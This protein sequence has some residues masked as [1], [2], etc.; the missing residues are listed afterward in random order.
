MTTKASKKIKLGIISSTMHSFNAE[1][2][3]SDIIEYLDYDK[4]ELY[5]YYT[6][7]RI[8][9]LSNKFKE[10]SHK[11]VQLE[12][13]DFYHNAKTIAEDGIHILFDT[14][15]YLKGQNLNVLSFK[16]A[17]IQFMGYG[18]WGVLV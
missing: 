16:P 2:F 9:M 14:V 7:V 1:R 11:F 8:D 3:V 12:H 18:F 17:P 4:I 10:L 5:C 13:D 6:G 15:G